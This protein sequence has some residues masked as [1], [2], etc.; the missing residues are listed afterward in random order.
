MPLWNGSI[1]EDSSES[2]SYNISLWNASTISTSQS[3]DIKDIIK[4]Y[5][6]VIINPFIG[7]FGI[8]GNVLSCIVLKKRGLHKSSDILLFT[9]SIVDTLV[10]TG[11]LEVYAILLQLR[12]KFPS[13]SQVLDVDCSY[14]LPVEILLY[15]RII[16]EGVVNFA[17]EMSGLICVYITLERFIA[18]F[19]P[20]K[21][22][23]IVTNRR[24]WVV[25]AVSTVTLAVFSVIA[26]RNLVILIIYD[27]NKTTCHLKLRRISND[28]D[29]IIDNTLT[30][31]TSP[32][33]LII[34]AAS[35]VAIG[36]KLAV[37]RRNRTTMTTTANISRSSLKTTKTLVAVCGLFALT[38]IKRMPYTVN[39]D[40]SA[41][42][43][44][45]YLRIN[46]TLDYLNSGLNWLVYITLNDQF[47]KMMVDM[48]CCSTHS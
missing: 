13:V 30:I 23:Q 14:Q 19:F 25:L 41:D 39:V 5:T 22:R 7:V 29:Q 44:D 2:T 3:S 33:A 40:W 15:F 27:D 46:V 16:L 38:Q 17:I 48:L 34:I 18:I 9:L 35:T 20:L 31:L 24:V 11:T 8:F 37:V 6:T 12:I 10:L 4:W 32:I 47:K 1:F 43:L 45:I 21:F 26:V 28:E 36:L 42:I